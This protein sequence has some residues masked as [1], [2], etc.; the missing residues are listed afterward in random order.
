MTSPS[1]SYST[2]IP[3]TSASWINAP[4]TAT[5]PTAAAATPTAAATSTIPCSL[6]CCS[7]ASA[8]VSHLGPS[9]PATVSSAAS[10]AP[11][12]IT[13][14]SSLPT[15][16]DDK[17]ATFS[18][19]LYRCLTNRAALQRMFDCG[20][21]EHFISEQ[22]SRMNGDK[23]PALTVNTS[24][25][26]L[27]ARPLSSPVSV[28]G[29]EEG[30]G[31]KRRMGGGAA[32][33]PKS[34]KKV[35]AER[36]P[37]S[38]PSPSTAKRGRRPNRAGA[39]SP[40]PSEPSLTPCSSPTALSSVL[41]L[42]R[43]TTMPVESGATVNAAYAA[44]A[45]AVVGAV[46]VGQSAADMAVQFAAPLPSPKAAAASPR[47]AA[48]K[49][50]R[51]S[52]PKGDKSGAGSSPSVSGIKRGPAKSSIASAPNT[53]MSSRVLDLSGHKPQAAT[54]R[55]LTAMQSKGR[56]ADGYSPVSSQSIISSISSTSTVYSA[57]SGESALSPSLHF[58]SHH[59]DSLLPALSL[60]SAYPEVAIQGVMEDV[61][62][63]T[64]DVDEYR[65]YGRPRQMKAELVDDLM[66]QS[67]AFRY[68]PRTLSESHP[69][70]PLHAISDSDGGAHFQHDFLVHDAASSSSS[71]TL[72]LDGDNQPPLSPS[73]SSYHS[74]ADSMD[75]EHS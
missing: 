21:L 22:T 75:T 71:A 15:P 13:V 50:A 2:P 69:M 57:S 70:H 43:S 7:P 40:A 4:V 66:P 29:D 36:P 62:H 19:L 59:T 68:R 74:G 17:L 58:S 18:A 14:P 73:S 35:K 8:A 39:A 60:P 26:A 64:A 55:A 28:K 32:G 51:R 56:G 23:K 67:G 16:S 54:P 45:S 3:V 33:S 24:A 61:S 72:S 46:E 11:L 10:S 44:E 1:F 49:A 6:A 12:S 20:C 27:H 41:A 38:S 9:T 47:R 5:T 63:T 31:K 25:A 37:K 48:N 30:K 53:P 65:S 42:V 52:T 34:A